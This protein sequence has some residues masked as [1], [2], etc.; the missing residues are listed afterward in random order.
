MDIPGNT[1]VIGLRASHGENMAV[2]VL[3]FIVGAFFGK[4]IGFLGHQKRLCG[5]GHIGS[6]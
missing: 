2:N 5:C 6:R 4:Q 1:V 3:A